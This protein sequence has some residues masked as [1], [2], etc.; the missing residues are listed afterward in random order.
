[1]PRGDARVPARGPGRPVAATHRA[2]RA[3]AAVPAPLRADDAHGALVPRARFLRDRTRSPAAA[4]ARAVQLPT[5]LEGL[6]QAAMSDACA[7]SCR[8]V[9]A[10]RCG[11][12]AW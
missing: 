6:R 8:S 3:R 7:S 2:A 12:A 10:F 1:M 11:A 5:P 4:E 9:A